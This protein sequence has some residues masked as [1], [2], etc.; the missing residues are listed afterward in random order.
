M[1]WAHE[2]KYF[3]LPILEKN[4][5]ITECI[6]FL[7]CRNKRVYPKTLMKINK[8]HQ[9][10]IQSYASYTIKYST[11]QIVHEIKGKFIES[12]TYEIYRNNPIPQ[13]YRIFSKEEVEKL[14]GKK[15]AWFF[16]YKIMNW[17]EFEKQLTTFC[18][19]II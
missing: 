14:A 16:N 2:R 10:Y 15:E 11:V 8:I 4:K 6:K 17:K 18:I 3:H 12:I 13:Y 19:S 5:N 1:L 7:C 9:I